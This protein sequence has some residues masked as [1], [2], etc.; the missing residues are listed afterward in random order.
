MKDT[1]KKAFK[2]SENFGKIFSNVPY[3]ENIDNVINDFF[4][5][6]VTVENI[7]NVANIIEQ[8]KKVSEISPNAADPKES[9]SKEGGKQD[10][11]GQNANV[12]AVQK[13]A[14]NAG[15]KEEETVNRFL[16][17]IGIEDGIKDPTAPLAIKVLKNFAEKNKVADGQ[18]DGYV[19]G[20][21]TD[22][23]TV[24]SE[25][26]KM[27]TKAAEAAKNKESAAGGTAP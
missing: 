26:E 20:L 9:S 5:E 19:D 6:K 17:R 11:K 12:R 13:A 24:K 16:K 22:Q 15:I 25:I 8:G 23:A 3:V 21:F 18:L 2:P 1:F 10:S 7:F 27:I 4:D 14:E